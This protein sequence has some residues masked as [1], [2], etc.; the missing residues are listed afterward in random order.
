MHVETARVYRLRLAFQEMYNGPSLDWGELILSLDGL[1]EGTNSFVQAA[2][3]ARGEPAE[4]TRGS[5]TG[6]LEPQFTAWRRFRSLLVDQRA[7]VR[8]CKLVAA[9]RYLLTSM[10]RVAD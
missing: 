8:A 7:V 5:S 6:V 2:Q 1:I 3:S 9:R 10:E 4:R